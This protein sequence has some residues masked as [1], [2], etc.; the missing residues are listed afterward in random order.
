[1]EGLLARG[2]AYRCFCTEERLA[3]VREARR[4]EK[5][6]FQGYDG[7]CRG[8]SP[9]E[10]EA[11]VAAGVP[12]VV[13]L[14]VPR[15]GATVV[16]DRLRGEVSFDNA[17]IDDQV[18]MKSDGMPTYHF[19]NVVDDHL[20][21]ISHVL[22][23]SEWL[24]TLPLHAHLIRAF[25]WDE[26]VFAHLSLFLKPSGKGKM[27]KRD[28]AQAMQDGHSIFI[29]DMAELGFL[30]EAVLNWI[31]LMGWSYDDH[32]EFFTLSDIIEKFSLD[33]LNPS[34]SAINFAKLDHFNGLHI[35]SLPVEDL[36]Q[37]M[38][39]YF[40][41]AGVQVDEAK[42]R[43]IVPIIR[44]RLVTL[45]DVIPMAGFFFQDT[46]HPKPEELVGK[47]LSPAE[48][49]A[50]A[51]KTDEILAV[52]PEITPETAEEPLRLL[53]EQLGLKP[54]QLFGILRVAVTGQTVSPPLFE[55]MS[56]IG[57]EKVLE[58]I[59]EAIGIL[60]TMG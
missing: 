47:G 34:P 52:L 16:R 46:V 36:A 59:R 24:S 7:T 23:G 14:K 29:S 37:R 15:E 17:Q 43:Q 22:R 35:R 11:K 30:P 21:E 8:L 57:K 20:M 32:T 1:M 49:A 39:P 28:T 2:T 6:D 10:V 50:A 51:C 41:A 53:A 27:S 56:I 5:A 60:K 54:G 55:S 40:A 48:S 19:A 13:R 33:K 12:F 4:A 3:A 9:A 42:L 45:D 26:P 38:K 58:R 31:A 25:G 44:E 18:L